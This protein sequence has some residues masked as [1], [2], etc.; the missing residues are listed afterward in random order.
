MTQDDINAGIMRLE[1]Q[2]A[3]VRPAEFIE[4]SFEQMVQA[5]GIAAN[6]DPQSN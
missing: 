6:V 5:D 1:V 4:V 2:V 3:L